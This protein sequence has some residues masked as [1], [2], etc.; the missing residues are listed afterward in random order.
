MRIRATVAAVSGA[1]A[2]SALAVPAAQAAGAQASSYQQGVAGVL[3]AAHATHGMSAFTAD[4]PAVAKPY[5]LKVGF[6]KLTIGKAYKVGTTN[7]VAFS[8]SY[9]L[10]H[11]ADVDIK[12]SDF[13]TGPIIYKGSSTARVNELGGEEPA[14]CTAVSSTVATCKGDIDVYPADGYLMNSD[15]GSWSAGAVAIKW[16]GQQGKTNPDYSKIGYAETDGLGTTL[17]QRNATLTTDASPEPVKKGATLTVK[18]KLSRANWE[19]NH[20]GAYGGQSVKLQFAKKGSTTYTTLTTVKADSAGNLKTTLKASADGYFRYSFAGN[21][22]TSAV[23]S[24]SDF[25]DVK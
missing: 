7:H 6:S 3:R 4:R 2:L 1:L 20:Y 11:G 16:N 13:N 18:G 22:T 23:T 9:T 14:T 17:I 19:T 15:A 5:A 25:V 8:V 12:S 10:T 21:S 24:T